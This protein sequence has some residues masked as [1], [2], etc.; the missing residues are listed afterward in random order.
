MPETGYVSLIADGPAHALYA[1]FGFVPTAPASV[2]M[3]LKRQARS[4]LD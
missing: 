3:A 4:A 2:G 1:Q